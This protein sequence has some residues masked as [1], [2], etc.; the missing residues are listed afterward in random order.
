MTGK[1]RLTVSLVLPEENPAA[2]QAF[3]DALHAAE[4]GAVAERITGIGRDLHDPG[5]QNEHGDTSWGAYIADA[6]AAAASGQ[7]VLLTFH[8]K[9][10]A[11]LRGGLLLD[12]PGYREMTTEQAIRLALEEAPSCPTS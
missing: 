11:R 10:Y 3:Y 9:P 12:E 6:L 2:R 1:L 5:H 7:T 8:G 4:Q